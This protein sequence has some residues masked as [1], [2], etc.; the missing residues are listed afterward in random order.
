MLNGT[1]YQITLHLLI[2]IQN[3]NPRH[4][5]DGRNINNMFRIRLNRRIEEIRLIRNNHADIP[6]LIR[7]ERVHGIR[8]RLGGKERRH[9]P[10]IHDHHRTALPGLVV[11]GYGHTLEEVHG[12]VCGERRGGTHGADE[13]DGFPAVDRGVDEEGG[14]LQCICAVGD[15]CAGHGGIAADK[16]V[17]GVC[18][19]QEQRGRDITAVDVGGLDGGDVGD[20]VHFRDCGKEF[21]DF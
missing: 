2:R 15:D 21:V 8:L 6:H 14:F 1:I 13:D 4:V 9:N 12:S 19:V 3:I 17:Q 16:R 5:L 20:V 18:E 10:V 7:L 11:C